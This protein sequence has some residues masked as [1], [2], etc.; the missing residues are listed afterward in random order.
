MP[1]VLDGPQLALPD[2]PSFVGSLAAVVSQPDF[3]NP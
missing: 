3:G 2:T 1:F